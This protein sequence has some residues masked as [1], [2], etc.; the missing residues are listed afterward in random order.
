[1]YELQFIY[2]IKTGFSILKVVKLKISDFYNYLNF[3]QT[4]YILSKH[5]LFHNT[6]K[7]YITLSDINDFVNFLVSHRW[8]VRIVFIAICGNR[9][10]SD[11]RVRKKQKDR[12]ISRCDVARHIYGLVVCNDLLPPGLRDHQISVFV[13]NAVNTNTRDL[14]SKLAKYMYLENLGK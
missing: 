14:L 6:F 2:L 10:H 3:I 9:H 4:L 8:M 11:I 13:S 1:M 5:N 7:L 12:N